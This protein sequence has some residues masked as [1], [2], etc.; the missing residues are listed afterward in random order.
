MSVKK[1]NQQLEKGILPDELNFS[2]EQNNNID[3]EKLKYN[4]FYRSYEFYESKF[5]NG[6]QSIPGFEKIIENIAKTADEED[7][8]PLK[9]ILER[10]NIGQNIIKDNI[11]NE[12]D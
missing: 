11:I 10:Q 8:T 4:A 6:Y 3:I 12:C 2:L 7:R 1:L 9:E 5:P